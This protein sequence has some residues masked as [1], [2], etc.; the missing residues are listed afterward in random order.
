MNKLQTYFICSH[1]SL[2]PQATL[3][4]C[5]SEGDVTVSDDIVKYATTNG[6]HIIHY[7]IYYQKNG[8]Q[9]YRYAIIPVK[10]NDQ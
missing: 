1:K 6:V 9:N 3:Q 7:H 4:T 10:Y 2:S 5:E 8:A